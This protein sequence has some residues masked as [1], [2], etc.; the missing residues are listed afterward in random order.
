MELADLVVINKAD[1]DPAAA[2]RAQAQ[3]TSALR[4]LGP[5]AHAGTQVLQISALQATGLEDFWRVVGDFRSRRD[6]SGELAARRRQQDA[7]WL[8]RNDTGPL[9]KLVQRSR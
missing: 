4:F 8:I 1:I 7:H 9:V 2:T 6:A 5:H 3:I